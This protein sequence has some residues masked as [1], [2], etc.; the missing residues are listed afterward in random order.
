MIARLH[1][2]P[3]NDLR[4]LIEES[5]V[6]GFKFLQRLQ[7]EWFSGAN[8]FDRDGEAFFGYFSG[9]TLVGVGGI[10]RQT[11]TCGRLRRC[12]VLPDWRRRGIGRRL[13]GH[14]LLFSAEFYKEVVLHTESAS[15]DAFYRELGFSRIP[16]SKDPTHRITIEQRPG[17]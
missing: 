7:D 8:R 9:A 14:I 6:E 4:P 15:A 10:N 16:N 2:L 5:R 1:E 12:Y 3:L 17:R 13:V 11:S